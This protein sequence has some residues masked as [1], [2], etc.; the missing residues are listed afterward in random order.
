MPGESCQTELLD[1]WIPQEKWA[2]KQVC[3]GKIAEARKRKSKKVI[4]LARCY[5][6]L[7]KRQNAFRNKRVSVKQLVDKFGNLRIKGI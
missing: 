2:W 4:D 3:E 1:N 5:L 7:V 6:K